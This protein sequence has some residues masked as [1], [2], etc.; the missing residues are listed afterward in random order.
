MLPWTTPGHVDMKKAPTGES[1][2]ALPW[3]EPGHLRKAYQEEP[4]DELP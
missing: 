1:T 4:M 2:D 3:T